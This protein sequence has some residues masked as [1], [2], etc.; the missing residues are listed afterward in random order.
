[1]APLADQLGPIAGPTARQVILDRTRLRGVF[2][3]LERERAT[4]M[5]TDANSPGRIDVSVYLVYGLLPMPNSG[6]A[7][8]APPQ[9]P[10]PVGSG[11]AVGYT[12]SFGNTGR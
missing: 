10:T 7:I 4:W 5:P 11:V 3:D 6:T 9:R 8:H 12:R 1:L 2:T